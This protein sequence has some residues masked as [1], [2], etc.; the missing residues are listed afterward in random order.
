MFSS[1]NMRHMRSFVAVADHGSFTAAAAVLGVTPPSLTT[2]IRQF[3]DVTGAALFDRTTRQVTLTDTGERFLPVAKRL[4]GDF[5]EALGDLDALS[6]GIGGKITIAAAPSVLTRILPAVISRFVVDHPDARLR[7]DEMNAGE[8]HAAV[9]ANEADFGIAGEWEALPDIA[10]RPLFSD[11]F[12]VLC[13]ADHAFACQSFVTWAE[14]SDQPFVGLG[15]ESGTS[16]MM[17]G[18]AGAG[19]GNQAKHPKQRGS[20]FT[21]PAIE[22]AAALGIAEAKGVMKQ[23]EKLASAQN[24]LGD[25]RTGKAEKST[26]QAGA[27]D[28]T[29]ALPITLPRPTVETSNTLTLAAMVAQGVG[30]TVLPELAARVSDMTRDKGLVFVPLSAPVRQRHIGIITRKSKSL[31]PIASLFLSKVQDQAASLDLPA[32]LEWY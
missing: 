18:V 31:S 29:A 16:A 19:S 14:L 3:E 6:K 12:G 20:D 8:V 1:L 27:G 10:F 7:L 26:A 4:I 13:R 32:A 9:A 2:T 30:I 28:G 11:R 23:A 22:A 17:A 24:K 5:E 21:S 15:P 25:H